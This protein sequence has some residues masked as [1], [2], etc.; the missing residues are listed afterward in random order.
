LD[1]ERRQHV[2]SVGSDSITKDAGSVERAGDAAAVTHQFGQMGQVF[3]GLRRRFA[4]R[5]S[6]IK[7][8]VEAASRKAS[9][10]HQ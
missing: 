1:R 6:L 10:G 9:A 4:G 2:V 5:V 3:A 7:T 8:T